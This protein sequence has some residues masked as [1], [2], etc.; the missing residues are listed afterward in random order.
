VATSNDI[1]CS[2]LL[3]YDLDQDAL[4]QSTVLDLLKLCEVDAGSSSASAPEDEEAIKSMILEQH[5]SYKPV[6]TAVQLSISSHMLS[7]LV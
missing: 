6:N 3:P 1:A 5:G 7:S 2:M 4:G